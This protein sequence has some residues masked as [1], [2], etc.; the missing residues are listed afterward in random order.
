MFDSNVIECAVSTARTSTFESPPKTVELAPAFVTLPS[1]LNV[2]VPSPPSYVS[3][4]VQFPSKS[5]VSLPAPI[6]SVVVPA[7][8]AVR[9]SAA[10]LPVIERTVAPGAPV[11]VKPPEFPDASTEPIVAP[12]APVI[13]SAVLPVTF[14]DGSKTP[15]I[16]K[17]A[18]VFATLILSI[19]K[20]S[21]TE[22]VATES[23]VKATVVE[24][25]P[26]S[27]N[28]IASEAPVRAVALKLTVVVLIADLIVTSTGFARSLKV[29]ASPPAI[30]ETDS[31]PVKPAVEI[32][33]A[34]SSAIVSLAISLVT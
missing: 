9:V 18:K 28:L 4:P 8:I 17:A 6:E 32:T 14:K 27:V 25:V 12:S 2:S 20:D 19:V 1:I 3:A 31:M 11:N 15:S 30:A 7:P 13:V 10:E 34:S 33:R 29:T 26:E 21:R 5:A 23:S 22:D 24:L 16:V